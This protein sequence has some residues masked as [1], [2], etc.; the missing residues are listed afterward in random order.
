MPVMKCRRKGRPGYKWGASGHCY[1]YEPG[2]RAGVATAK[3]K[4]RIQG[5]AVKSKGYRS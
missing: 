1:T 2:S 5:A 4:A 3:R